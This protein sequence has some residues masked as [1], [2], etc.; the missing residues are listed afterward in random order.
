MKKK[1]LLLLFVFIL[2]T[3][4]ACSKKNSPDNNAY[5]QD[6]KT[7]Y[8][9]T[10]CDITPE[11]IEIDYFSDICSVMRQENSYYAVVRYASA[12]DG[13]WLQTML[14]QISPEGD[15]TS[16]INI[17]S[18]ASTY[19]MVNDN[20]VCIS[21]NETK[22]ISAE[23]GS[24]V[25]SYPSEFAPITATSYG[26]NYVVGYQNYILL[27]DL[28][29]NVKSRVV[30]DEFGYFSSYSDCIYE[31]GDELYI[32]ACPGF[33][34]AYFVVDFDNQ[35]SRKVSTSTDYGI[36]LSECCGGY[37]F[38]DL[39]EY[40]IDPA[41][42]TRT[43][44]TEWNN[45]NVRPGGHPGYGYRYYYVFDDD[46]FAKSYIKEDGTACIQMYEYDSNIDYSDVKLI[47]VGGIALQEEY[48]L[49]DAIY[50]FN[51]SQTEYR[52]IT[53][54]F[55]ND[56]W[57]DNE[58]VVDR[59]SRLIAEFSSGNAP[60]IFYGDMFDYDYFGRNDL[61]IDI[62]PYLE[63]SGN[64]DEKD[65]EP[66]LWS[67]MSKDG[68]C[69]HLFNDYALYGYWGKES[70]MSDKTNMTYEELFALYNPNGIAFSTIY[71]WWWGDDIIVEP[72]ESFI[73][74]NGRL[75]LTKEQIEDIVNVAI[76][77]GLPSSADF[78]LLGEDSIEHLRYDEY[79]I[80]NTA[81]NNLVMYSSYVDIANDNLSFVGFPSV[82]G[83]SHVVLTTGSVAV[84]S[85]TSYPQA[86]V[87]FISYMF[88]DKAQEQ[89][90]IS[91]GNSV[92]TSINNEFFEFVIN[93]SNATDS[94]YTNMQLPKEGIRPEVVEA[95]RKA[96][97]LVDT[98]YV[99]D[100]IISM[101]VKEEIDSYD[102][103][104]KPIDQIAESL[105]SRLSLYINEMYQ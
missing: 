105:Y 10:I 87:D 42:G 4:V 37:V 59:N 83:A 1:I 81:F 23:D 84:S 72:F 34:Y 55:E 104:G 76:T 89:V 9:E 101:M 38:D 68:H 25:K 5:R 79:L 26:D 14:Y 82:D 52:V 40:K 31:Y 43:I 103:Q 66:A 32:V 49:Q 21:N 27:M 97:S 96:I 13:S 47:T 8:R 17:D 74:D 85:S 88:D 100:P 73:D 92:R 48:A 35:T 11:I 78:E 80:T 102:L 71:S 7:G 36:E 99:S 58:Y 39:G 2:M 56:S 60:D 22:V 70:L 12:T 41:T 19:I 77:Y 29:G 33:E 67:V 18:D 61:V 64:F 28:D 75:T 63:G 51:S 6:G 65:I 3:T 95:Y 20:I 98:Q 30:D 93:P 44:L 57:W 16:K 15:V 86:C 53:Q 94:P 91:G 45:T 90:I 50:R 62:L 46:H 54:E 24:M 69:Y